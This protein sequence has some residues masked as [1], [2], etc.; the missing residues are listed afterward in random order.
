MKKKV[1]VGLSGG[2]DSSAAALLLK[3][4][5][6]EVIGL[7]MNNWHET[8]EDGACTAESDYADVRRVCSVLDIP[9]YTV[10]LS[11][12]YSE[13]VFKHF[14]DEYKKG[15]TPNP[16][17]LCNREIKFGPFVTHAKK[18]GCDFVATGHYCGTLHDNGRTYLTRAR[19]ENKCQTYFLS[20]VSES[21]IENAIFPLQNMLKSEVRELAKK[22]GLITAEKKDSTGI[23]FI[24]ERN[25][26]E[27]LSSY[28]PCRQGDIKTL[29]GR[30]VGTHNG[31]FFYTLGQ[32]KGLGLGGLHGESNENP[33][34]VAKRD[35]ENNILYVHQG[36][37][38]LLYASGL[39]TGEFNFITE[40]ITEAARLK[41][42]I[43]HRQPLFDVTAAPLPDGSLNIDFDKKQRAVAEGQY[44]VLY[45][46][47]IC[48]GGGTIEKSF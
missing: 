40:K 45:D 35:V 22:N 42:R 20:M 28:I 41:A 32:R 37:T 26:R 29:D 12:Q 19:D 17:V 15:R 3:E 44:C 2:V 21:Q 10:D 36:E 39:V 34:F 9:Y 7:F 6:Y 14:I 43:R 16:D 11:R 46:G 1:A 8:G 23:C 33:W 27:F 4:Q 47:D 30:T 31:V 24:G 48:L 38:D 18:L 25:F 13:N 5:G